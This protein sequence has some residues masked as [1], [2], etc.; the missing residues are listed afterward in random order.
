MDV[1]PSL[2]VGTCHARVLN[3]SN[4]RR[5][6]LQ[7]KAREVE[8]KN[9]SQQRPHILLIKI[10]NIGTRQN[11]ATDQVSECASTLHVRCE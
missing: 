7:K 4:L 6:E 1:C 8:R 5:E 3:P 2:P 10:A 9:D 11:K